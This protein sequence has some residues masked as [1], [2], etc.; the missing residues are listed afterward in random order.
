[1]MLTQDGAES[2]TCDN[3]PHWDQ[4]GTTIKVENNEGDLN[5]TAARIIADT[6]AARLSPDPMLLAWYEAQSGKFSPRVDCCCA[7]KKP[8][9]LIYAESRGGEIQIVK[10]DLEY[11]FIYRP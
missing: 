2:I 6:E 10:H 3:T 11:V 8:G 7:K 1:M 9:W 5:I 4:L